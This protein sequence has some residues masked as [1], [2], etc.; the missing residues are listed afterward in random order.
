MII[1]VSGQ[2]KEQIISTGKQLI[3]RG[4]VLATWGNISCRVPK[5]SYCLITPSGMPYNELNPTDLVLIGPNGEV[6]EGSRKPSTEVLLHRFIYH[7]RPDVQAIVHTHSTFACCFA[8]VRE[9]IPVILEE[10][11]QLIGGPVKVAK[12]AL[13][14]SREL[15]QN[16][17]EALEGR[18]AILLANHGVVAVGASI[19]EAFTIALLVEKAAQVM[20]GAKNLAMP[21]ILGNQETARLRENFLQHY[22]QKPGQ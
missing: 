17:V 16:A 11:A 6:L 15:G 10:M 19:T 12:Y 4:L 14:G 1:Q 13:P 22:G 18:N 3:E 2:I 8:V 9:Q 21:Y 7:T 5:T 20:M